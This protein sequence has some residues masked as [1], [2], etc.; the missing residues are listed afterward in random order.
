MNSTFF[1]KSITC[2]AQDSFIQPMI[3][4][5]SFIMIHAR[6][7]QWSFI[8]N[9]AVHTSFM[10]FFH[11]CHLIHVCLLFYSCSKPF[12]SSFSCFPIFKISLIFKKK[13]FYLKKTHKKTPKKPPKKHCF[14][15]PS[16]KTC[17]FTTLH[18]WLKRRMA[19]YVYYV[20]NIGG[21]SH[22]SPAMSATGLSLVYI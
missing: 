15:S 2:H 21:W 5:S 14:I 16:K 3:P 18:T 7:V 9:H 8:L 12:F 13:L 17:F 20:G 6:S 4:I 11:L 1:R 10:P 22:H 19:A